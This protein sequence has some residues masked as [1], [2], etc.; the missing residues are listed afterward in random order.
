M[1]CRF[2]YGGHTNSIEEQVNNW[3]ASE[4][5]LPRQVVCRIL[6]FKHDNLN[7]PAF[8]LYIEVDDSPDASYGTYI[9]GGGKQ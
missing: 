6:K 4:G 2:F 5:I 3:F 1:K 9:T 7:K 8:A